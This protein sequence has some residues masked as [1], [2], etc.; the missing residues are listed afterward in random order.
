MFESLSEQELVAIEIYDEYAR[1]DNFLDTPLW[2]DNF[3]QIIFLDMPGDGE[4]IDV[5]CGQGRAIEMLPG[6]YITKYLGIDPSTPSIEHCQAKWP[7]LEFEVGEIREL[8]KKYPDRFSGFMSI[9][10]LMH[11]PRS[12]LNDALSSLRSCLKQDAPGMISLPMGYDDR[13]E[14]INHVGMK[15]TLFTIEEIEQSL[16]KNGFEIINM[17]SPDGYMLLMHTITI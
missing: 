15:L 7:N 4:V 8:G 16:L 9:A 14:S 13:L 10:M 12:D 17:F 11:I 2:V 6:L 5:G 3:S 1:A